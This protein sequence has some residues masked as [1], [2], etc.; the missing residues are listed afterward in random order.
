MRALRAAEPRVEF[1]GLGGPAMQEA[2][3]SGIDNW[4]EQAAV[5]GLSEVLANYRYFKQRF[6]ACLEQLAVAPPAAI[7]LVDYPGFNL[8][9]AKAI[10]QRGIRTRVLYYIS[11][12]VWAWKKGRLKI[13]AKVLDLMICIFPFEKP[14]YEKSGLCTEFAG[15]PMVDRVQQLRQD[16]P[17]EANLIGW[18]PGSRHHEVRRHFPLLLEA[19]KVIRQHLPEA[20]FVAS[21]ANENLAQQMRDMVE[22]VALPEAKA[23]VQ[24]GNVY[25]LMQRCQVGAVASGTAT[26]EAACFGL[27][28]VLIYRVSWPTYVIGKT[29]V[30]IPYLGIINVLAQRQVVQELIQRDF[31]PSRVAETLLEMLQQPTKREALE[32]D[33]ASVVTTLGEGG[34]YERAAQLVLDQLLIK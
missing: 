10:R 25:E 11:P 23:W 16:I 6:E 17:R 12:Q 14:L 31:S 22:A 3:G 13:M 15:H 33:L 8:R 32:K 28:Y 19:A 21:A 9:L 18:F 26:L 20:R 29:L 2:F 34:A 4:L 27:P 1:S 7:I 24:V 5:V 30:R